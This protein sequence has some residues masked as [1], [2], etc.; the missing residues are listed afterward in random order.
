LQN[1]PTR[2]IALRS[3]SLPVELMERRMRGHKP[4]VI[5][6][7]HRDQVRIDLRTVAEH[8]EGE[9]EAALISCLVS[10]PS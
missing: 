5:V 2:V 1:V 8:E 6:R 10:A 9:L 7:I 3:P 4:P